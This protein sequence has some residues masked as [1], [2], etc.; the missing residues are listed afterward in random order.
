MRESRKF[1]ERSR[2]KTSD[3][4]SKK[5]FLVFEGTKTEPIYF[6]A[7]IDARAA[8]GISPLIALIPIERSRGEEGWSNPKLILETLSDNL[9]ERDG[10]TLTYST[11]LNAMIE[12]LYTK[13]Y[14]RRRGHIIEEI[15][16]TLKD[17]CEEK[18]GKSLNA[19]IT[20]REHAVTDMLDAIK[21][22]KPR[23]YDIILE[24]LADSIKALQITY[25]EDI[26]SLCFI[27]DRDRNSFTREQYTAVLDICNEKGIKAF[28]TNPCFEF[29]LLLHFDKV[30]DLDKEKLLANNKISNSKHANTETV[31]QIK[32]LMKRYSKNN[33]DANMLMTKISTAIKN[34]TQYCESLP[35]LENQLGST[36][37]LLLAEIIN[38]R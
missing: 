22:S 33:Y 13:D 25:A 5:Y 21:E 1:G 9:A 30:H 15:W 37:G 19:V 7:V 3:E 26:D 17:Q 36:V 20:D 12:C 11:L 16:E 38:S 29:W 34:E 31:H 10:H 24:N 28:P 4:P 27:F 23:V 2:T 8:L 18:L 32:K 35:E 14:I 6:Q